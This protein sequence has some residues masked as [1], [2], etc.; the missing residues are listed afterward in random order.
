[1]ESQKSA[2][3][4]SQS[5][6]YTK[7]IRK[8]TS[9]LHWIWESAHQIAVHHPI[10]RRTVWLRL[11]HI[12]RQNNHLMLPK[13]NQQKKEDIFLLFHLHRRSSC[14]VHLQDT[15]WNSPGYTVAWWESWWGNGSWSEKKVREEVQQNI[16][17]AWAHQFWAIWP[18]LKGH[19]PSVLSP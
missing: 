3:A 1:M 17:K 7:S 5:A 8:P 2:G 18:Q 15:A 6:N 9:I 16:R 11:S 14:F 12:F 10:Y 13:K 19:S 4:W